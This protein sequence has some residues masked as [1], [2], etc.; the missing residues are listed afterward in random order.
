MKKTLLFSLILAISIVC[1]T[2]PVFAQEDAESSEI[3][4]EEL[5]IS[6]PGIFSWFT[7]FI[8]NVR[9]VFTQDEITKAKLR[10]K[11]AAEDI[12]KVKILGKKDIGDEELQNK[13][14][15][16]NEKYT[17][18][19]A[20]INTALEELT[21]DDPENEGL[22]N[23]LDKYTHQQV[24]HMEVLK[25]MEDNVPE[26][27][28]TKIEEKRQL[29]LEKFGENMNR[30]QTATQ[31]KTR[32]K[33]IFSPSNTENEAVKLRRAEILDELEASAPQIKNSVQDIK[34]KYGAIYRDLKNRAIQIRKKERN[35]TENS[36][37]TS[38]DNINPNNQPQGNNRYIGIDPVDPNETENE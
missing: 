8:R 2:L 38:N 33:E 37:D 18:N 22:K 25:N 23:F 12:Y 6:E 4:A 3:T 10:L 9:I 26:Q 19:I 15:A 27:V 35:S 1:I 17:Q 11:N 32:L 5:E 29:H 24:K 20:R 34:I 30:L 7:R 28:R 16:L 21:Q 14:D 31:L 13:I 36:T